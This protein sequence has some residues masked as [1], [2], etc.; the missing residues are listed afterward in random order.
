MVLPALWPSLQSLVAGTEVVAEAQAAEMVAALHRKN[1]LVVEGAGAVP[2]SA[3]IISKRFRG[4]KVAAIISGG[5]I[6]E[7]VLS[8]ILSGITSPIKPIL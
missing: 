6:D 3:A 5:N 2:V 1:H 8:Q 4:R 7:P